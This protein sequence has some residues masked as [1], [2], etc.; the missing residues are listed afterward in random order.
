[1]DSASQE[2]RSLVADAHKGTSRVWTTVGTP[3]A[4]APEQVVG[5]LRTN[6]MMSGAGV[7][8]FE[9][10]TARVL[11][12]TRPVSSSLHPSR[13]VRPLL[14]TRCTRRCAG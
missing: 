11:L 1:M 5:R 6:G 2:H 13:A 8:L 7:L 14:D 10:L 12:P 4:M 3:Y 9:M